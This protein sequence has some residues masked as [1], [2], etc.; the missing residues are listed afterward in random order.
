[1]IKR[2]IQLADVCPWEVGTGFRLFIKQ[3]I[4]NNRNGQRGAT[5]RKNMIINNTSTIADY[6]VL[7]LLCLLTMVSSLEVNKKNYFGGYE[8]M[9]HICI[10]TT[11]CHNWVKYVPMQYYFC[12]CVHK[13]NRWLKMETDVPYNCPA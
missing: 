2:T 4:I 8:I 7:L 13:T 5:I 6:Y 9:L 12:F 1:M 11:H 10:T 3:T